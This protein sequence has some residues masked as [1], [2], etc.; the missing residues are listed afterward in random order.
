VDLDRIFEAAGR[1]GIAIEINADPH[2]LDLDWRVLRRAREA[3]V[4]ISIGADAH[5]LAGLANVEYG[6]GI[7][8]K[9]GLGPDDILN[10]RSA[11]D[12]VSFAQKRRPR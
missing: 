1:A 3:G 7:A 5:N 11:D 10:C 8:R 12:F 6:V 2:R 4:M 9:G